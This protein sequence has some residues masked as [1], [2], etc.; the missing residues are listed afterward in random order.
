M[1]WDNENKETSRFK[2]AGS[3]TSGSL[4]SRFELL[5]R[6]C[7]LLLPCLPLGRVLGP[8]GVAIMTTYVICC[9]LGT[10]S[11]QCA[12]NTRC[13]SNVHTCQHGYTYNSGKT[14]PTASILPCGRQSS[15]NA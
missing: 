14:S 11:Q 8:K 7:H 9:G 2:C 12:A 6:F 4:C 5:L 1:Y 13:M 15:Q 10:E 3:F